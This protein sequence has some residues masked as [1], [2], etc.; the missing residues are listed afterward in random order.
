MRANAHVRKGAMIQFPNREIRIG[1]GLT[2]AFFRAE[3]FT[4]RRAGYIIAKRQSPIGTE[5]S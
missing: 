1:A 3:R 4:F 5:T 2:N